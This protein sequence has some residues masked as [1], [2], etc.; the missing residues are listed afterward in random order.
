MR[1]LVVRTEMIGGG[2]SYGVLIP[3]S[4]KGYRPIT[5]G[6]YA[7][8]IIR[9][10]KEYYRL[11]DFLTTPDLD[12]LPAFSDARWNAFRRIGRLAQR[13]EAKIAIR[14]FPELK[15]RTN[16]PILWADWT[17]PSSEGETEFVLR[18]KYCV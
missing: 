10:D 3:R 8:V 2:T 12:N 9:D 6:I 17:L 16:L 4:Q 1:A 11:N 7:T 18:E 15:G 13:L 5:A 14:V